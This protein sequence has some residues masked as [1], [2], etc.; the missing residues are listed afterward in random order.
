M[1]LDEKAIADDLR[2]QFEQF[3]KDCHAEIVDSTS[4]SADAVLDKYFAGEPP[5]GNK[6]GKEARVP[7]C[8]CDPGSL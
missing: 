8:I 5:F 3:L 1:K 4:L 7:R 2:A 6:K